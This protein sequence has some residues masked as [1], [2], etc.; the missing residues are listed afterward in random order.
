V[1]TFDN[2]PEPAFLSLN[3][4]CSFYGTFADKSATQEQLRNQINLDPNRFNRVEA[5]RRLTDIER[6]KLIKNINAGTSPEWLKIYGTIARDTS[7]PPGLKAYFL[8]VD[9]QSLDRSFLTSYR[10]RYNARIKLLKTIAGCHLADLVKAFN[11]VDTYAPA[12]NPKD[13]IEQRSLKAVLL[14]VLVEA[15]TTDVHKLAADHFHRAWNITDRISALNCINVSDHPE[16]R[17][18]L[19]EG[20]RL[21]KDHLS[22]YSSYLQIVGSGT[23][24]DVFDMIAEEERRSSF[25]IEHPTHSRALYLPMSGNNKMLWTD[26][27]IEWVAEKVIKL[28]TV[29]ENTAI[30]LLA[31]FQQA[32]NLADDLKKKVF[33]ALETMRGGVNETSCPSVA[34]RINAYLEGKGG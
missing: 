2:V 19:D 10:E 30:R 9:E 29:N 21:W 33:A 28:A 12:V 5:M 13:G 27:G 7:L 1:L 15:N 24:D 14:R 8:R 3:R 4:D 11:A 20:Y 32:R 16:R 34:G 6:I 22:A 18:L 25:R 31:C 26:K 23:H 17:N